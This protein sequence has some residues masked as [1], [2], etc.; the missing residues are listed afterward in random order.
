MQQHILQ[1]SWEQ[2]KEN[3]FPDIYFIRHNIYV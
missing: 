3:Q 1:I 2:N